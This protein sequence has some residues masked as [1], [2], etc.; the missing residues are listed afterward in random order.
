MSGFYGIQEKQLDAKRR[1][2]IPADFRTAAITPEFEGVWCF[3]SFEADCIEGGGQALFDRYRGVIQEL[4]HGD[5]LRSALET[6][7]FGGM[8]RLPFDDAGRILLSDSLRQIAGIE[9]EVV[10]VGLDDRFQIWA[11]DA[12]RDQFA[13][14]RAFARRG[15]AE[16]R[17]AQ[18][19]A[20]SGGAA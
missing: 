8:T 3:P 6:S 2:L 12:W 13:R 1:L 20:P 4:P 11:K 18:R 17:N 16:F 9:S 19:A 14:Q 10:V 15:L 7:V 5:E